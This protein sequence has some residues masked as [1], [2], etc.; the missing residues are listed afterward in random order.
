ME[1]WNRLKGESFV[2]TKLINLNSQHV[3][4]PKV[5][6][7]ILSTHFRQCVHVITVLKYF[8]AVLC[9]DFKIKFGR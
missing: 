5:L 6:Y 8:N 1:M 3:G 9:F 2:M 7:C 4:K